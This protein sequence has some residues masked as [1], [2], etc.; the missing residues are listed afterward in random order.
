VPLHHL[1]SGLILEG[2][3]AA[4]FDLWIS[5][6]IFTLGQ[7]ERWSTLPSTGSAIFASEKKD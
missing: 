3:V 5:V 2:N 7:L 1:P 4:K 6:K